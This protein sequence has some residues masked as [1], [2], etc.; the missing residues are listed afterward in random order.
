MEPEASRSPRDSALS[1]EEIREII[2][3]SVE[4]LRPDGQRIVVLIPD[5]TRSAP[6]PFL[7]RTLADA[8]S[9]RAR[10]AD[11]LVALGTHPPLSEAQ[12]ERLVGMSA[13]ERASRYPNS[14]IFNHEWNRQEALERIGTLSRREAAE[15]TGGML[16]EEIDIVLNRR[17]LRDYDL[18]LICGPVFPHE[19]VGF[20]GG[21]KYLFPGASGDAF[22][23]FFHWLGALIT[24]P[25]INGQASTPVRALIDKAA[26]KIPVPRK[27]FSFVV[28][29]GNE[30]F[31]FFFGE[32]EDSWARAVEVSKRLHIRIVPRPYRQVLA[33]APEMYD[34]LWVGGKCMYKL[35]PVVADGGE[36][37]IYGP[38]I[39]EVSYTHGRIL[40]EVG[41][42]TRDYFVAQWKTFRRYPWGVLAHSTHVKGIGTYEGGVETPRIRVTLA[43]GIPEERCLRIGLGYR[44]PR[45]IRVEEWKDRAEEGILYVPRAG[46]VLYRLENPPEWARP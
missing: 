13:A 8:L 18:I 21:N 39:R 44:D 32:P 17:V 10:R 28:G 20:S 40:D 4:E 35:E 46:E 24:N 5:L 7:F 14:E 3:R 30:I 6:I 26:R 42:H 1:H 27:A 12:I 43:T 11:F 2:A 45:S 23:Q 41:Y 19:V 34:D 36:L 38:H 31:G 37:I 25:K 16:T 29:E 33:E 15:L 22:L 9:P